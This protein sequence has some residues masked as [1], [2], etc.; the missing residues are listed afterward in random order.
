MSRFPAPRHGRS[1]LRRCRTQRGRIARDETVDR[2]KLGRAAAV[3]A[4]V[5]GALV[6]GGLQR[7]FGNVF[8]ILYVVLLAIALV[9]RYRRD[10]RTHR[11]QRGECLQCGYCLTGNLSGVCPECGTPAAG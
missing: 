3:G 7:T 5:G 1:L 11:L 10:W 2:Q 6:P 9:H 8:L 4:L